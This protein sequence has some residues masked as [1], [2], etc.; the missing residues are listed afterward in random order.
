MQTATS[1]LPGLDLIRAIAILL[2]IYQHGLFM[3]YD[4]LPEN[5]ANIM[6]ALCGYFGVELFFVLS[7]FLV[8]SIFIRRYMEKERYGSAQVMS[9]WAR[10][11]FRTLPNYYLTLA[12]LLLIAWKNDAFPDSVVVIQCFLFAQ[13]LFTYNS[14]FFAHAWS[15][16]VEE[17]F[18]LSLP[19]FV[20]IA[21]RKYVSKMTTIAIVIVFV[22]IVCNLIRVVAIWRGVQWQQLSFMTIFKLDSIMCGVG[23]ALLSV[24]APDLTEKLKTLCLMIGM[25]VFLIVVFVY[26]RHILVAKPQNHYGALILS[27]TPVSFALALPYFKSLHRP[28][29]GPLHTIIEYISKISYSWYLNHLPIALWIGQGLHPTS[30]WEGLL[31]FSIY[32]VTTLILSSIQYR[33]WERPFLKFRDRV[34]VER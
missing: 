17:W 7:G 9:F 26:L 11:W 33:Y 2:V 18:Y 28:M 23:I 32:F 10:R 24:R 27:L 25:F 12:V 19:I 13:N 14:F 8:G 21:H 29:I 6:F 15:L 31:A 30:F 16:A 1:R 22:I 3:L 20:I 34:I 4:F 5:F